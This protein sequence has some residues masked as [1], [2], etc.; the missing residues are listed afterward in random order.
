MWITFVTVVWSQIAPGSI[1][2]N[3]SLI[4]CSGTSFSYNAMSS[5]TQT[6]IGDTSSWQNNNVFH[7]GY[8]ELDIWANDA[9]TAS[10]EFFEVDG[11]KFNKTGY[12]P[13]Q[14]SSSRFDYNT[15]LP[16][17]IRF[18]L[19]SNKQTLIFFSCL[20]FHAYFVNVSVSTTSSTSSTLSTTSST[21]STTSSTLSTISSST[22][23]LTTGLPTT[24]LTT[25]GTLSEE[26]EETQESESYYEVSFVVVYILFFLSYW[27]FPGSKSKPWKPR[28]SHITKKEDYI[29]AKVFY[30]G[31]Y[32]D[33]AGYPYDHK[34]VFL[35][36]FWG[37]EFCPY[38]GE[39][40]SK[41]Q[42][43]A[44]GHR[45]PLRAAIQG[46]PFHTRLTWLLTLAKALTRAHKGILCPIAN[47]WNFESCSP[48]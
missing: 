8:F 38:L 27:M 43:F 2:M 13:I 14:E 1:W 28:L 48:R 23:S 29:L 36:T 16:S 22:S 24:L 3:P 21:L 10:F 31:E 25:T 12:L 9:N 41:F 32:F 7:H 26:R 6:L 15:S 30:K 20:R 11:T 35:S 46:A 4:S 34:E 17:Q 18:R 37:H 44:I 33:V 45:I 47:N 5:A 39:H 40:D 42:L 19:K